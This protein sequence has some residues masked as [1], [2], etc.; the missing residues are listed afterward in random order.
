MQ[1]TEQSQTAAPAAETIVR[2]DPG[3]LDRIAEENRRSTAE[4]Y[5]PVFDIKLAKQRQEAMREFI[6][7]ILVEGVDY[8]VIPNTN[9]EKVLK[10]PGAEK[11]CTYFGLSPRFE[12]EKVIED[13]SGSG[14]GEGEALFYYRYKCSLWRGTDL[15]A[16]AVGS[17]NSREKK[18]RWRASERVCPECKKATIIKGR[19]EY[20][21]G[22]L[23]F[24]KK[25]GCGAKF[26]DDDPAI[27][28]QQVGQVPNPDIADVVNTCQKIAQKRSLVAVVLIGTNASDSFTQDLEEDADRMAERAAGP[29]AAE[30]TTAT[31]GNPQLDTL[32]AS[33]TD[34]QSMEHTCTL[35]FADIAD[36]AGDIVAKAAWAAAVKEFGS[37]ARTKRA[38]WKSMITFL[39]QELQKAKKPETTHG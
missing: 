38:K 36:L 1:V 37:D 18:Y 4:R 7:Q 34:S 11:L 8:G 39:Y 21:G 20:G 22:F 2:R 16:E 3:L 35:L 12:A 13:W 29:A 30:P 27:V 9:K 28:N 17:C 6:G 15:L 31:T 26:T 19:A 5:M 23:C 32:I 14:A 33:A 25:G 24:A 10:K